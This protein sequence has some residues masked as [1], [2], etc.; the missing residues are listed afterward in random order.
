MIQPMR[1]Q[2]SGGFLLFF[3]QRHQKPEQK[4]RAAECDQDHDNVHDQPADNAASYSYIGYPSPLEG[5]KES[6]KLS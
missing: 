2:K 3:R 6:T 1:P 4:H 5:A